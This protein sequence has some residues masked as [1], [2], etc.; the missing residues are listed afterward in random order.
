MYSGPT[1]KMEMF[2]VV[3]EEQLERIRVIRASERRDYQKISDV[4]NMTSLELERKESRF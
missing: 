2:F 4:F 1:Q 3:Y